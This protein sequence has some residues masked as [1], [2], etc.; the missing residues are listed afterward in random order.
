MIEKANRFGF[1]LG[2]F[3][4]SLV[5]MPTLMMIIGNHRNSSFSPT[6]H[7]LW[8]GFLLTPVCSYALSVAALRRKTGWGYCLWFQTVISFMTLIVYIGWWR[9]EMDYIQGP[10]DP[11]F[12]SASPDASWV[13][14]LVILLVMLTVGLLPIAIREIINRVKRRKDRF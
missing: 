12:N 10:H 13:A 3:L 11:E 6:N 7:W 5:T 2:L 14:Y 9:R 8:W 1:G 4:I